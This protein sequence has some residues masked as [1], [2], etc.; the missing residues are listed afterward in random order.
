MDLLDLRAG[1]ILEKDRI[2]ALWYGVACV[3]LAGEDSR[4]GHASRWDPLD[5]DICG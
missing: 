1:E 5:Q 2:I 3:I 4:K